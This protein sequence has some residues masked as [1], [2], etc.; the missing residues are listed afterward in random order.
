MN[1]EKEIKFEVKSHNGLFLSPDFRLAGY[2][3]ERVS[4]LDLNGI[5]IAASKKL[6]IKEYNNEIILTVKQ[7]G[8]SVQG[9]KS[10]PEWQLY[11]NNNFEQ[12]L[13]FFKA[14]GMEE[15]GYYEK[16]SRITYDIWHPE[17]QYIIC[18]DD[19]LDGGKC[20]RFVEVEGPC[21]KGILEMADKIGIYKPELEAR[22]VKESYFDMFARK[23]R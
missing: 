1:L 17:G 23:R 13:E 5:M 19:I 18:L 22:V 10:Q 11:S 21:E 7:K 3:K 14:M 9:V 6:R 20:R 8:K 2:G 16:E 15:I 4:F 12:A